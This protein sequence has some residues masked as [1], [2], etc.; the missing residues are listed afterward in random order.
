MIS[1]IR[2]GELEERGNWGG[3]RLKTLDFLLKKRGG[4]RDLL[5]FGERNG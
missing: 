1:D 2:V 5:L 4:A 3:G